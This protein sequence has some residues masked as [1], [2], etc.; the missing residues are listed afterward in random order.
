MQ[1]QVARIAA[2]CSGSD[3]NMCL[4]YFFQVPL[5]LGIGTALRPESAIY[6]RVKERAV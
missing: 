6:L 4:H 5:K 3:G 2:T 1:C